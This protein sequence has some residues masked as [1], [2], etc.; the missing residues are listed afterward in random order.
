MMKGN[1]MSQTAVFDYYY[2]MQAEAYSFY[3]IPKVLFSDPFFKKVSCEA[4]V[5]YGLMLDRMSLSVKNKWFDDQGRVYIN[6]TIEDACELLGCCRQTAVKL[7]AE[8]D[9]QKGIGLIEKKRLGL[10]K[11]NIIYVKNFLLR[12]EGSE[13]PEKHLNTQKSK[14]HTSGSPENRIQ[15]VQKSDFRKSKNLTSRSSKPITQEVY[16]TDGNNTD[17]SNTDSNE[18]K[19][20]ETIISDLSIRDRRKR[21]GVKESV[22]YYAYQGLIKENID[23]DT[24]C[25]THPVENVEGIVSLMTDTVCSSRHEIRIGGDNKPAAVVKS[26]LLGLDYSHI[27]YVMECMN[28]NTTKI[29]DIK[30]YLL[31]ALY[32]AP[33]TIGHYYSAEANYDLYGVVKVPEE[34]KED[35]EYAAPN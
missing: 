13:C 35:D 14:N 28:K 16:K 7:M 20:N 15:E 23:Y 4:K 31:T 17:K 22:N 1:T 26:R 2:G 34:E 8:L 18:T 3:R 21:S 19:E 30:Q 5:L 29:H 25:R 6:F 27:E 11:A 12:E 33:A 10:G 24:L 9:T 32:N